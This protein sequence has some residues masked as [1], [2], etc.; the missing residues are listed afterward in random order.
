MR[1]GVTL[2]LAFVLTMASVPAALP[3]VDG[4]RHRIVPR[5]EAVAWLTGRGAEALGVL[6]KLNRADRAHLG[7]LDVL[8]V[9]LEAE[10]NVMAHAPLPVHY[11]AAAALPRLLVVD[12][13][14]QAFGGYEHGR[15]VR[16]GPVSSGRRTFAT[17]SGSFRLTW[18]SRGRRSSV[19]P[20]WYMRWYFNFENRRGLA[21]H[22]YALPGRPASHACIRLLAR[23]A[24]WLYAWGEQWTLSPEGARVVMPGTPVLIAGAFDFD[25]PPPWRRLERLAAGA[26]LPADLSFEADTPRPL[27]PTFDPGRVGP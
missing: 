11:P 4:A 17:P 2:M 9:P 19:N 6:E 16:W 10:R 21:L 3:A 12:L 15:L 7:R 18:K 1:L 22:A 26:T 27:D 14:W 13:A 23:D 20:R 8:V 24:R 5:A 25:A